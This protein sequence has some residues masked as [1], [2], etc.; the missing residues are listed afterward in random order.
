MPIER[1]KLIVEI[2]P[3]MGNQFAIVGAAEFGEYC[4]TVRSGKRLVAEGSV[5]NPGRSHFSLLLRRIADDAKTREF[6]RI[7]G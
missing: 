7:M 5:H 1:D 2:V 3:E 6:K 4:Y